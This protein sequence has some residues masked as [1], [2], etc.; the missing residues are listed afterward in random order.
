MGNKELIRK[1]LLIIGIILLCVYFIVIYLE[2]TNFSPYNTRTLPFLLDRFL[3]FLVPAI[4]CFI[5][6]RLLKN[7]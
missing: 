1:I 6:R 7:K 4:F 2:I 5:A 3:E